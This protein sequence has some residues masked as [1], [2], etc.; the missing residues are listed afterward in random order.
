MVDPGCSFSHLK[1]VVKGA[2]NQRRK[3]LR[4]ALMNAGFPEGMI[5]KEF[6]KKRAEQLSPKEFHRLSVALLPT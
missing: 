3:T 1:R 2:F 5:P 4:N 6:L